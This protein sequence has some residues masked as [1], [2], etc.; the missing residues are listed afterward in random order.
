MYIET[1][2]LRTCERTYIYIS[3]A[4]GNHRGRAPS[5]RYMYICCI[6]ETATYG[7]SQKCPPART[8][9]KVF[10]FKFFKNIRSE[11][12]CG[13]DF[14]SL[15][16]FFCVLLLCFSFQIKR[17][18]VLTIGRAMFIENWL[19]VLGLMYSWWWFD[20]ADPMLCVC[21]S[22]LY[23]PVCLKMFKK[24]KSWNYMGPSAP[25]IGG[26]NTQQTGKKGRTR[27]I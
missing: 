16:F 13:S 21:G 20:C 23:T 10:Y 7:A 5:S 26:F 24:I 14:I 18:T 22:A 6:V 3:P 15:G 25:L 19:F 2:G 9:P 12:L 8:I 1:D 27:R 4:T 17:P 11:Y